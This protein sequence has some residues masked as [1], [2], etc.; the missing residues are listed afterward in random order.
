MT[1]T[2]KPL[3]KPEITSSTSEHKLQGQKITQ[4]TLK[5]NEFENEVPG[6]FAPPG[7]HGSRTPAGVGEEPLVPRGELREDSERGLQQFVATCEDVV[8]HRPPSPKP[9]PSKSAITETGD[10]KEAPQP[11]TEPPT[12]K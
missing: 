11:A 7:F 1:F 5:R 4:K 9:S 8:V 2:T 6:P 3:E 10:R 12:R